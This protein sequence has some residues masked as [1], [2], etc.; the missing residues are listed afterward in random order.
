[1]E[2][3]AIQIENDLYNHNQSEKAFGTM[4]EARSVDKIEKISAGGAQGNKKDA[5][6]ASDSVLYQPFEI[7][8]GCRE[9]AVVFRCL[10]ASSQNAC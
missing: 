6:L 2:F 10:K 7:Q 8:C 1:M 4:S 5:N 9:E 3:Y